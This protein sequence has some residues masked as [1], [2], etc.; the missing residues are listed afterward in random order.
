MKK[1]ISTTAVFLFVFSSLFSAHVGRTYVKYLDGDEENIFKAPPMPFPLGLLSGT[2]V[3]VC[4]FNAE[5]ERGNLRLLRIQDDP[6]SGIEHHRYQQYFSGLEVFGGE[7]I[8][9]FK[10]NDL[11][12]IDGEYYL[13]TEME[14]KPFLTP[15]QATD[16]FRRDLNDLELEERAEEI[17]LLIF[18]VRDGETRLAYRI[19]LER[20]ADYSMTG[21]IDAHSG[22]TLSRYSNIKTD[23]LSIGTGIGV[24]GEKLKL[25]TNY[26]NGKY[27]L[28][29]KGLNRP[30]KQYTYI[31]K[32]NYVLTDTDNY[33]DQDGVS[34]SVH[35]YLG[36]TYNYYYQ[37][38]NRH[39]IDNHNL[40]IKAVIHYPGGKDNA[41]WHSQYMMMFFLDPGAQG[42]QTAAALDVI[43]HEFSHGVTQFTS[44]LVY[45]NESGALNESFS[46]IMGT[47]VEFKWQPEGAGFLKADWYIGEDIY[48]NYGYCLR[49]LA[50]P[51]AGG[52]PCHLSQKVK[53]PNTQAGDWGGVH[54]N[55]T[56]YGHAYYLLAH[57]GTNKISNIAVPG[58][59]VEKATKIFYNAFTG[60]LTQTSQFVNAAN[61]L[62]KSASTLFGSTSN[63]YQQTVKAMQAIGWIV[64]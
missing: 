13:I 45:A 51:N 20:G 39:G 52:Y 33:W 54:T 15:E 46:D 27:W 56:I 1:I 16:F 53:L 36:L 30:V 47:A 29:D 63:E 19:L 21:F 62:L 17:K 60:Y 26:E 10:N 18:P 23:T 35:A 44:N 41:F 5:I 7:I 61:G 48:S 50:N 38:L 9:H 28:M 59:G 22:E 25:S 43:A 49:N 2:V 12:E 8:R 34:V 3:E 58:I 37:V 31:Q 55:C 4:Y 6:L 40:N 11:Q 32:E 57:G 42:F 14:L 24:H 64:N